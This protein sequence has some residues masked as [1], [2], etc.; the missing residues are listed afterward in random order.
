M[1]G[2]VFLT[3]GS[4]FVGSA[5]ITEL[6]QRDYSIHALVNRKPLPI[7]NDRLKSFPGGLFDPAALDTAIAGCDSIIHVV[8][9]I[10]EQPRRDITFEKLHVEATQNVVNAAQRAGIKRYI[11]MSALG[12]HPN[13]ASRYHQTKYQAE[14]YVQQSSLDWTI[15]RPSLIH[16]PTGEF[17]TMEAK[18]VRKSAP[19]YLFMPYFGRGLLGT[20]GAGLLQPV[21]INDVARAFVDALHLPQS[22]HQIYDLAGAQQITWPELHRISA[23][24]ILGKNRWVLPLPAWYAK[25][26]TQIVPASLLPFNKDQVLMSQEDNTTDLTGF[27]KDFGFAPAPF[28]QSLSTYAKQL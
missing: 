9:I 19:P 17:M 28:E 7:Q 8:G 4:G 13:A 23:N 11:H 5:I 3:G 21:F 26:L 2:N 15:F 22:I 6:L 12:V 20:G 27:V 24:A 18:W 1:P 25:L 16:G 14:Q 10:Q